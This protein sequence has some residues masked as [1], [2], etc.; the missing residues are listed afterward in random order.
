MAELSKESLVGVAAMISFEVGR[1]RGTRG[2]LRVPL[3][4]G[5]FCEL[6]GEVEDQLWKSGQGPDAVNRLRSDATV[7]QSI[8]LFG[9]EFYLDEGRW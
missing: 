2:A 7:R 3:S 4:R 6:C 8:T 9:T 5:T 1:A